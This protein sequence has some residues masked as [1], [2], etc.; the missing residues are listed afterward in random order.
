MCLVR[1][2]HLNYKIK[3]LFYPK[4][5][6]FVRPIKSNLFLHYLLFCWCWSGILLLLTAGLTASALEKFRCSGTAV[7]LTDVNEGVPDVVTIAGISFVFE[8]SLY[9]DGSLNLFFLFDI[10]KRVAPTRNLIKKWER[11]SLANE[12]SLHLNLKKETLV[13]LR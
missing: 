10:T 8:N 3:V 9:A 12:T 5:L 2:G 1:S 7:E 6:N 13:I 4:V 11:E